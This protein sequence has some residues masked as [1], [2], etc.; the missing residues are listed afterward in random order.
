MPSDARPI[1]FWGPLNIYLQH[2][3][4]TIIYFIKIPNI[5]LKTDPLP[6][7]LNGSPLIIR[8][9][10]NVLD[11]RI[12][13]CTY[14][15]TWD[16]RARWNH[17]TQLSRHKVLAEHTKVWEP[18][19]RTLPLGHGVSHNI[20]YS[21]INVENTIA[22]FVLSLR[23]YN[24]VTVIWYRLIQNQCPNQCYSR[25]LEE[26]IYELIV[27]HMIFPRGNPADDVSMRG[28][29]PEIITSLCLLSFLLAPHH[30]WSSSSA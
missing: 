7:R 30:Y 12:L 4:Q 21:R 14:R 20:E 1:L 9:I 24:A 29:F 27:Y 28:D 10:M 18:R 16:S 3:I 22:G 26:G 17:V 11:F 8:L 5:F 23:L 13:L 6:P 19:P 25:S 2:V 15:L